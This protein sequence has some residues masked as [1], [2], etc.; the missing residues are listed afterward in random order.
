MYEIEIV[1]SEDITES[2]IEDL[3][4]LYTTPE[5]TI[6]MERDKGIDISFLSMPIE[7]AQNMYSV[8]VIK[9]TRLYSDN[10]EVSSIT[11]LRN[12]DGNIKAKVVVCRGE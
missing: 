7:V 8:E 3:K 6:P 2:E 10:I 11:F 12:N 4:T 1:A 5:G 9:K